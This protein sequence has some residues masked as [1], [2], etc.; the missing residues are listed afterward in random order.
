M[1]EVFFGLF[2]P[3]SP[4]ARRSIAAAPVSTSSRA[5]CGERQPTVTMSQGRTVIEMKNGLGAWNKPGRC[6]CAVP[7]KVDY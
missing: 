2:F 4:G 3:K 6:S 7:V 5:S 1:I